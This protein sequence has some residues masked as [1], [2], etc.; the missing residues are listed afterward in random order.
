MAEPNG[1]RCAALVGHYLSGKTTLISILCGLL[2]ASDGEAYI[3]E[4]SINHQT[5]EIASIIGLV[6][7]E[8]NFNQ[9][10]K[11]FEIVV[12]QAGFYGMPREQAVKNAERYLKTPCAM[13]DLRRA[14]PAR[15]RNRSSTM[16]SS[17]ASALDWACWDPWNSPTLSASISPEISTMCLF[18]IWTGRHI[19]SPIWLRKW[20]QANS[21]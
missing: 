18:P 2:K 4:H 15:L 11:P 19:R 21:A 13:R 16:S 5:N 1:A 7:Q 6:P 3:C 12:N 8:L 20:K 9:F 14:F 10:E 17:M